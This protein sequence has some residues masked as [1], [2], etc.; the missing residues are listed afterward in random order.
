MTLTIVSFD[1]KRSLMLADLADDA[2]DTIRS[3]FNKYKP[4]NDLPAL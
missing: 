4:K 3:N 2:D 1:E